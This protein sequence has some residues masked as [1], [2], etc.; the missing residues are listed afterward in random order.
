MEKNE[1]EEQ[2]N[3]IIHCFICFL[4]VY[5]PYMCPKCHKLCC[6]DCLKQWYENGGK[7]CAMCK[8]TLNIDQFIPVPWMDDLSLYM[9]KEQEK[10][11]KSFLENASYINDKKNQIVDSKFDNNENDND[12]NN[13]NNDNDNDNDI[14][15]YKEKKYC[16]IHPENL[17]NY[18]CVECHKYICSDCLAFRNNNHPSHL[19][20]KLSDIDKFDLQKC[21]DLLKEIKSK[22]NVFTKTFAKYQNKLLELNYEKENKI[23]QI[24]KFNKTSISEIERHLD[25]LKEIKSNLDQNNKLNTSNQISFFPKQLRQI[26]DN[27]DLQGYKNLLNEINLITTNNE[28]LNEL[29]S[30]CMMEHNIHFETYTFDLF[31]ITNLRDKDQNELYNKEFKNKIPNI[32]VNIKINKFEDNDDITFSIILKN[33]NNEGKDF[34]NDYYIS[35][36]YFDNYTRKFEIIDM[37]KQNN[38]NPKEYLYHG[39]ISKDFYSQ[40]WNK[41]FNLAIKLIIYEYNK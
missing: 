19:I 24:K 15:N 41:D 3:D 29:K 32:S 18:F 28:S 9:I 26:I 39:M 10:N 14:V 4:K 7:N 17:L 37:I 36:S 23:N 22:K 40:A 13:N 33:E 25:D 5:K 27:K 30:Y 20:L 34:Q 2:V 16:D 1:L 21:L 6:Y 35:L 38:Y 31:E 8:T 12:N 11:K